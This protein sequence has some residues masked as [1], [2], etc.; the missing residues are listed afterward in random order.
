MRSL[1]KHCFYSTEKTRTTTIV[2]RQRSNS[3]CMTSFYR[4]VESSRKRRLELLSNNRIFLP[5]FLLHTHG[6][7]SPVHRK[8]VSLPARIPFKFSSIFHRKRER[9]THAICLCVD[10]GNKRAIWRRVRVLIKSRVPNCIFRFFARFFFSVF[11]F[12]NAR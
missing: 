7:Y 8:L 1:S 10:L 4:N 3:H 6:V 2:G 9:S 12:T 11:C 5:T